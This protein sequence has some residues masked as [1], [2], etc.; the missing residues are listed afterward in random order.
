MDPDN[1]FP[2]GPAE[3]GSY[4]FLLYIGSN[5]F[6][7]FVF[8]WGKSGTH[9]QATKEVAYGKVQETDGGEGREFTERSYT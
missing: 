3:A 2:P 4:S 5:S 9:L 1:Q 7:A 6:F 8:E